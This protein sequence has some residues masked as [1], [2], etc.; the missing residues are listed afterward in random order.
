MVAYAIPSLHSTT[1]PTYQ[2][3][4]RQYDRAVG[5]LDLEDGLVEF[6][7]WPRRELTVNF[8][9]RMD[10]GEVKVFLI[11]KSCLAKDRIFYQKVG[12]QACILF[13]TNVN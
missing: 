12:Q 2:T 13:K 6:M 1:D 5:Y 9:V 10:S 3:A 4:L 11:K 7:K 8:P